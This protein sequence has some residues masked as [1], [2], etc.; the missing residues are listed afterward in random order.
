MQKEKYTAVLAEMEPKES[1]SLQHIA[2]SADI[3]QVV[4]SAKDGQSAFD[5]ATQ[6]RPDVVMMEMCLPK[7]DSIAL[8]EKL[9]E[10]ERT[11]YSRIIVF[12]P[13]SSDFAV[14]KLTEAGADFCF[15]RPVN[16]NTFNKRLQEIISKDDSMHGRLRSTDDIYMY[17]ITSI[18]NSLGISA[19]NKG[20]QYLRY[21]IFL[22]LKDETVLREVTERIYA[23]VAKKYASNAVCVERNMRHSIE[24]AWSKGNI[25]VIYEFFGYSVDEN[26]GKPTNTAFIA[27]VADRIR[28]I[29]NNVD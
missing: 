4:G 23:Q 29:N 15:I 13:V 1:D 24:T 20:F 21:A 16:T 28:T 6:K 14:R 26:R 11:K 10:D 9:R 8:V 18:M 2:E 12:M 5:M 27:T 3:L 22:A 19:Q 7:L 17:Q 25:E